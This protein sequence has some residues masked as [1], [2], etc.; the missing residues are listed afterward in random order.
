MFAYLNVTFAVQA[1]YVAFS[2][3]EVVRKIIPCNLHCLFILFWCLFQLRDRPLIE[4][5][6]ESGKKFLTMFPD[7]TGNV[8]YPFHGIRKS[9]GF[10]FILLL[11]LMSIDLHRCKRHHKERTSIW[12]RVIPPPSSPPLPLI[13]TKEAVWSNF[14]KDVIIIQLRLCSKLPTVMCVKCTKIKQKLNFIWKQV[15]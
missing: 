2:I 14:Y 6:Y 5:F 8:L 11:I 13:Y 12:P 3:S 7:G 10:A 15:R 9:C 4:K 1:L